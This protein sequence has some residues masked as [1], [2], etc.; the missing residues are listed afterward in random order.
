MELLFHLQQGHAMFFLFYKM[1]NWEN[2]LHSIFALSD[3][4]LFLC[5][6]NRNH[7]SGKEDGAANVGIHSSS[8]KIFVF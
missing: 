4:I 3:N 8:G 7:E 6:I 1:L 5:L 2:L